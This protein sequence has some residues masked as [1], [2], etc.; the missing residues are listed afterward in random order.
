[1]PLSNSREAEG[2]RRASIWLLAWTILGLI[3]AFRFHFYFA[4][5][6][7][8]AL[9]WGLKDWYLWGLLAPA[10]VAL[11]RR[12]PF[13]TGQRLRPAVVL[14]MLGLSA[15]LVHAAASVL[16]SFLVEGLDQSIA[17]EVRQLF[18]KKLVSSTLIYAAL[19]AVAHLPRSSVELDAAGVTSRD[20]PSEAPVAAQRILVRE[21]HQE[22]FLPVERIDRIEAH[23]NYVKIHSG[24]KRYLERRTL[25]SLE[26]QLGSARFLRIHRSHLVNI[27]RIRRIEASP[28]GGHRVVLEDGSS[29]SLSRTFR[30]KLERRIGQAF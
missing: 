24:S 6:W 9:W 7:P 21:D 12:I 26:A 3:S 5:D 13:R 10:I 14:V 16:L 1:M 15:A 25:A 8:L 20:Q 17:L 2:L 29:Y 4:S 30:R 27:E 18:V 19:V 28:T 22:I 23:G 11:A